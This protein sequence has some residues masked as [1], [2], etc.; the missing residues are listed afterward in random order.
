MTLRRACLVAVQI[1]V[2]TLVASDASA[3]CAPATLAVAPAITLTTTPGAQEF[4]FRDNL[5][6]SLLIG[7]NPTGWDTDGSALVNTQHFDELFGYAAAAGERIMRIH[8]IVGARPNPTLA[9]DVDCNWLAFWDEVLTRADQNG[10]H[11]LPVFG[12]HGQ[13]KETGGVDN[14]DTNEYNAAVGKTCLDLTTN[15][16]AA[17]P[18]GLLDVTTPGGTGLTW[19]AWVRTVVA[20]WK[21]RSNIV[22][23]EIFSEVDLIT[24]STEPAAAAFVEAA[25]AEIRL[26]DPGRPVTASLSGTIDWPL[27]NTSSI[28]FIQIHPYSSSPIWG[29][30][31]LDEMILAFVRDRRVNYPDKPLFVGESGLHYL[32]PA[33]PLNTVTLGEPGARTSINQ[34]IWAGV[35]SGA[36]NARTLWWEDG[37][38]RYHIADLCVTDPMTGLPVYPQYSGY[39]ECTDGDSNTKLTLRALYADAAAPAATFVQG[40]DYAGFV[41]VTFTA[42]ANVYGAALGNANMVLGWVKD[43]Q[44]TAATNWTGAG[45]LTGETVTLDVSGSSADWLVDFYDPFDATGAVVQSIDADQDQAT[46]DITFTLPAFTG[47]IA[48]KVYPVPPL[49]VTIDIIPGGTQNRINISTPGTV[50]V[51]IFTGADF[52]VTTIDR[53]TLYF[54]PPGSGMAGAQP[55]GGALVDLDGDGD[56]DLRVRF[57]KNTTGFACGDTEGEITGQTVTGRSF[58]GT[59]AVTIRAI[60]PC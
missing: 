23:W 39:T 8:V 48:F 59:D 37:F 13:W 49:T 29:P 30:G 18:A 10:L 60:P 33:D 51:G 42:G 35:V 9:G 16:R 24:G 2:F 38:D 21:G 1:L 50:R 43:A 56:L 57:P 26:E 32:Q 47:S 45:Q 6:Q 55:V 3:Q 27:V 31:N 12:I 44:S 22:G 5:T 34:A 25:A 19:I 58:I 36:M 20:H 14:W 41:P 53:S 11:V 17:T 28:D 54:G 4:Y 46:G 7:R 15:C 52:D 40:V